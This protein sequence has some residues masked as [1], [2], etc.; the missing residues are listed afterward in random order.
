[1]I[2]L[3]CFKCHKTKHARQH[4]VAVHFVRMLSLWNAVIFCI[5]LSFNIDKQVGFKQSGG[6]FALAIATPSDQRHCLSHAACISSTELQ[7]C[8][9][10]QLVCKPSKVQGDPCFP[11]SFSTRT[12]LR[13][14]FDLY[15]HS[16][17]NRL[18][19]FKY[20]SAD[21]VSFADN[22]A[23]KKSCQTA[24][25]C[26]L[27]FYCDQER[28]TC[29]KRIPRDQPCM[30]KTDLS[31]DSCEDGLICSPRTLRCTSLCV[32][33]G[34]FSLNAST[35]D[36]TAL[37]ACP[38]HDSICRT[39]W[40]AY[41]SKYHVFRVLDEID[42][43]DLPFGYCDVLKQPSAIAQSTNSAASSSELSS[44][45]AVLIPIY[46]IVLIIILPIILVL[47]IGRILWQRCEKMKA[48]RHST[49]PFDDKYSDKY[50]N[51]VASASLPGVSSK[52]AHHFCPSI[53]VSVSTKESTSTSHKAIS[54]ASITNVAP[55]GSISS[56][57]ESCQ[58]TPPSATPN[59][60]LLTYSQMVQERSASILHSGYIAS[61]PFKIPTSH[62]T[63][64][65]STFIPPHSY[66]PASSDGF[67]HIP[68]AVAS[69]SNSEST[70]KPLSSTMIGNPVS[71]MYI[72][73]VFSIPEYDV[74]HEHQITL[75]ERQ[76]E[77]DVDRTVSIQFPFPSI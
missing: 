59:Q 64:I 58:M 26:S 66:Q 74:I 43:L 2:L 76:N 37:F 34:T 71:N 61:I 14:L 7:Y 28:K 29:Q 50:E 53:S 13:I 63:T 8:A 41:A 52:H 11:S 16:T 39:N 22:Q 68:A 6:F 47:S 4:S 54:D 27:D 36:P 18:R 5:F 49:K 57:S 38:D 23:R 40:N 51:I 45:S 73:N 46:A 12:N 65:A 21:S 33:H 10:E 56:E 69:S 30:W 72:N 19:A 35:G 1:M 67:I 75:P 25:N 44:G 15:C 77:E 20:Q 70:A 17:E 3:F 24:T 42:A 9:M 55:C 62:F 48:G 60:S 32:P 31:E